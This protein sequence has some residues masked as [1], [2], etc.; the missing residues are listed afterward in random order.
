MGFESWRAVA[1]PKGVSWPIKAKLEDA[2]KKAYNDPEY[3]EFAKKAHFDLYYRTHE[4]YIKFLEKQYPTIRET[5]KG[6][7]YAK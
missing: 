2:F 7:G 4:Q 5:L 6:M 3:Q 1:I